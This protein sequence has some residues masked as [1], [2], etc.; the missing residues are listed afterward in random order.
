MSSK[1]E[2]QKVSRLSK[3]AKYI[4]AEAE[5]GIDR[6]DLVSGYYNLERRYCG[7]YT[8][9][10]YG[11]REQKSFDRNF[12]SAQSSMTKALK[13]LE[14]AGMVKLIRLKGKYIKK[15]QLTKKGKETMLNIK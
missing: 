7:H 5:G 6:A 10:C 4:L 15:V 12:K 2:S 13:R 1:Y 14:Q 8:D 9:P 3:L 11:R